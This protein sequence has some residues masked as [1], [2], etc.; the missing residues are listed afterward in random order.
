MGQFTDLFDTAYRDYVTD[1][2]PSSGDFRPPKNLIRPIGSALD[3]AIGSI[4]SNIQRKIDVR[5][6][7][8]ANVNLANALENGDT[9]NGVTLATGDR[10]LL[11]GQTS[12][13]TITLADGRTNSPFNGPYDVVASGAASR[14]ADSNTGAELLGATYFVRSGTTGT[15]KTWTNSA[16]SPITPGTTEQLF[17]LTS[18]VNTSIPGAYDAQHGR[19]SLPC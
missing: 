18:E 1:G 2:V 17:V 6:S 16:A 5:V 15:G 12:G 9:L 3:A 11:L 14:S 4:V 8:F 13:A 19:S 10:V 7:A